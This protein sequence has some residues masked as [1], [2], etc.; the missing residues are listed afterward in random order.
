MK[1]YYKL[2]NGSTGKILASYVRPQPQI[3]GLLYL[4]EPPSEYY[5]W[6]NSQWVE[7]VEKYLVMKVSEARDIAVNRWIDS[8]K[9]VTAVQAQYNS[10]KNAHYSSHASVDVGYDAFIT[11]LD[12]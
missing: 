8:S 1:R 9:L 10:F 5:E 2:S 7:D 6:D 4:E 12:L 3:E 11:W